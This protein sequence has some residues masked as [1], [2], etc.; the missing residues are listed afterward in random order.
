ML[1]RELMLQEDH[2]TATLLILKHKKIIVKNLSLL[3][4]LVL[5]LDLNC[6]VL[7]RSLIYFYI[8]DFYFFI[9]KGCRNILLLFED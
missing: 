3:H 5:R 9:M 1:T 4:V 6:I 8:R 2:C 7:H